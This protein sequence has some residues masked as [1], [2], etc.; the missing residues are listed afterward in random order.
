MGKLAWS[1][2]Q[3]YYAPNLGYMLVGGDVG[4]GQYSSSDLLK[5][6][7]LEWATVIMSPLLI[8]DQ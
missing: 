3:A 1:Y 4:A 8:I 5:I 7:R 6:Y 2:S